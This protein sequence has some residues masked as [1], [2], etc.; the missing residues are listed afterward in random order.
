MPGSLLWRLK[1]RC[2]KIQGG[3]TPQCLE[4]QEASPRAVSEG[5]SIG[6][7]AR[8]EDETG[9]PFTPFHPHPCRSLALVFCSHASCTIKIHSGTILIDAFKLK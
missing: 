9:A 4:G 6:S 7:P 1:Q 2:Q 8:Q 3:R 5:A